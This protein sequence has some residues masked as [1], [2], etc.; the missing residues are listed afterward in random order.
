MMVFKS[1][2]TKAIVCIAKYFSKK[3]KDVWT[4]L[5]VCYLLDHLVS[6][7]LKSSILFNLFYTYFLRVNKY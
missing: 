5:N 4:T 2:L 3:Y 6:M 1:N 7:S